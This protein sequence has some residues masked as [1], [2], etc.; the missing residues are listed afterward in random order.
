MA[1]YTDFLKANDDGTKVRVLTDQ[2]R[3]EPRAE[4][5]GIWNNPHAGEDLVIYI[6]Y[7]AGLRMPI[8]VYTGEVGLP[9]TRYVKRIQN[10]GS[11]RSRL[12]THNYIAGLA[13]GSQDTGWMGFNAGG[14]GLIDDS[15]SDSN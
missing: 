7:T 14:V 8:L 1:N 13:H 11:T 15:E 9:I 10:A 2:A 12:I 3:E 4:G 6:R 5:R